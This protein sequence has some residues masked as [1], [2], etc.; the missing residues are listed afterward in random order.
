MIGVHAHSHPVGLHGCVIDRA[1]SSDVV[2]FVH[3]VHLRD[4]LSLVLDLEFH[5]VIEVLEVQLYH[6]EYEAVS[7][8]AFLISEYVVVL[9]HREHAS[10]RYFLGAILPDEITIGSPPV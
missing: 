10:A 5:Q 3:V 2:D 6:T 1:H 8:V 4:A 9:V 7:E